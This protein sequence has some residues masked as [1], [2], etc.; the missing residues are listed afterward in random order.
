MKSLVLS[1][2]IVVAALCSRA[3][4]FHW[5]KSG[6][7]NWSV[8][9]RWT[10]ADGSAAAR[11][12]GEG[13][14]AVISGAE[15]LVTDDDQ[16]VISAIAEI[17][18]KDADSVVNFAN[19]RDF[20]LACPVRGKGLIV[21]SENGKLFLAACKKY[22]DSDGTSA[23][24]SLGDHF[25]DRGMR[26]EAGWVVAPQS[27]GSGKSHICRL[28]IL[29]DGVFQMINDNTQIFV[30]LKGTGTVTNAVPV[31]T[32]QE[33]KFGRRYNND[34]IDFA[35]KFKGTKLNAAIWGRCRLTGTESTVT[36]NAVG[37]SFHEG[38]PNKGTLELVSFGM[39]GGASSI[40]EIERINM[41]YSGRLHY[42]GSGE[43]TDKLI[44]YRAQQSSRNVIDAG[45]VGGVDFAGTI[46]QVQASD[47]LAMARLELTGSNA[48]PCVISGKWTQ[49]TTS[50]G[51]NFA[52]YV[53]KTGKGTWRLG[54]N[55]AST[56]RGAFAVEEGTLQFDSIAPTN[57]PS[58]LG[59]SSVL[60][61]DIGGIQRLDENKVDYAV[62]LGGATANVV[63]EY[64]GSGWS[65]TSSR[66]IALKGTVSRVRCSSMSGGVSLLGGTYAHDAGE[67]TL[68]LDGDG[69][70]GAMGNISDGKGKVNV[71]KEG[72]GTWKLMRN[73]TFSGR[74]DV[75]E[76]ELIVSNA[77]ELYRWFRFRVLKSGSKNYFGYLS[78]LAVYD[79]NGRCNTGL[80]FCAPSGYSTPAEGSTEATKY[81]ANDVYGSLLQPGQC[82]WG[83]FSSH[84]NYHGCLIDRLFDGSLSSQFRTYT[85]IN[86]D[87]PDAT[88]LPIVF[89]V[90][91]TA[92]EITA[93]DVGCYTASETATHFTLDGSPDGETWYRLAEVVDATGQKGKTWIS[94]NTEDSP[95]RRPDVAVHPEFALEGGMKG[96]WSV[97]SNVTAVTV[98]SGATLRAE[99]D[100]TLPALE[101][102]CAKAGGT[103][104]GFRLGEK[105]VVSLLNVGKDTEYLPI[106]LT[107][108]VA[109]ENIGK[110]Q[111]SVNGKI[112]PK[113]KV[114]VA[115]GSLRLCRDG[116][117]VVVR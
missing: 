21:K 90:P 116:F 109:L 35:G 72:S 89:R 55:E 50:G 112:N 98:A 4:E 102:D 8:P 95:E 56:H 57:V 80:K 30:A 68:V 26:I 42:L 15:A 91:D 64:T 65:S 19:K 94:D 7:G 1:S 51:T 24:A 69:T 11:A 70:G 41:T 103:V 28:E 5:N 47:C 20:T 88:A 93:F 115:N 75:R 92:G 63:F 108:C 78:E 17:Q 29:D 54:H 107:G 46:E 76:G 13:D 105:G 6:S 10:L 23:N 73:Q 31:T 101:I 34:V 74:L 38:F 16:S 52:T 33:V 111:V 104:A 14:V 85:S 36:G 53:T 37:M 110:W 49:N 71:V 77:K 48:I 43:T 61:K 32:Y 12:P 22:L 3:E 25:T 86:V 81:V 59:L 58:A 99:G 84:H 60:Y 87:D 100:V 9:S 45:A 44:T 62:L 117:S 113:R 114:V 79:S 40:G 83:D 27:S 106:V 39:K 96:D 97:L 82:C 18:L 66:K 2:L 67:K